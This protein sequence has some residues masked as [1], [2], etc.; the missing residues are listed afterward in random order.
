MN[1]RNLKYSSIF[2]VNNSLALV[3][4][5]LTS[6]LLVKFS[7]FFLINIIIKSID[8]INQIVGHVKSFI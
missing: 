2:K 3:C 6:F 4:K 1:G 7:E 5:I 8:S